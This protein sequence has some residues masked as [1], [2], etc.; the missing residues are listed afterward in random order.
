MPRL[1]SFGGR[2]T[3]RRNPVIYQIDWTRGEFWADKTQSLHHPVPHG[4]N[5][6]QTPRLANQCVLE[7]IILWTMNIF[8][9]E[10]RPL[11]LTHPVVQ[12]NIATWALLDQGRTVATSCT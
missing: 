2:H 6:V 9:I 1:F 3:N 5:R 12:G 4:Q 11:S 7:I 10:T 8:E